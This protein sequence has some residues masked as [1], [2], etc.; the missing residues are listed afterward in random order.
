MICVDTSVWLRAMHHGAGA[1]ATH[2]ARLMRA[3]AA[4]LPAPVRVELLAGASRRDFAALRERL[5]A[6][7]QAL[8][9][10]ATWTRIEEWLATA[11]AAG[12]RFAVPD[13]LIA[14]AAAERGAPVWSF[15]ADFTR[16]EKLGFVRR[17]EAP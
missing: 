10:A 14:A 6:L 13:L 12:E 9:D 2:L 4:L 15:D 3:D 7:P 16:M 1:E 5:A 8:P 17:Y 11:V